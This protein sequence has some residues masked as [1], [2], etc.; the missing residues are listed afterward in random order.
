M[1][2]QPRLRMFAGP[3]GSGK[4]TLKSVINANLLGVYVNPD[5]IHIQKYIN[6]HDF[7]DLSSY[8][9]ESNRDEILSF[10]RSS[11]LLKKAD[12]LDEAS[13]L[14]FSD[15]KLSFFSTHVNAYFA[16][17]ASD[18]IRKKLLEAHTSF[19]FETV[20][21]F[22][23]KIELL[24]QAQQQGFRTY[25]Y[26]IATED[27]AINISRVQYRHNKGGHSVPEDKNENS[28]HLTYG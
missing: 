23:D 14:T 27:P 19:S 25:L 6:D 11:T 28:R 15:N 4:S 10:F 16:S 18:F 20:M 1:N 17:V 21:S 12:M 3:N 22:E 9:I 5:D 24:K 7:L 13:N 26:Y 2:N 8:G